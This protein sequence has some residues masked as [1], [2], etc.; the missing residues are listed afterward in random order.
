MGLLETL[1]TIDVLC[2]DKTG[3]L[4]QNKMSLK[5]LFLAGE[6]SLNLKNLSSGYKD[7]FLKIISYVNSAKLVDGIL[8]GDPEDIALCNFK[9]SSK[10]KFDK[11]DKNIIS[12]EPF[13]SESKYS[14]S[15]LKS[16]KLRLKKGAPEV[17][18]LSSKFTILNGK[19]VTLNSK[20]RE[21][22]LDKMREYSNNSLRP[23]GFSYSD[24]TGS[25]EVF[26][27]F[28][29]LYDAPKKGIK[30]TIEKIY[31]ANIEIKMITG[32]GKETAVAI[33]KECGFRDIKSINYYELVKLNK[34]EFEKV[35]LTYNV[36]ARMTPQFKE[37]ILTIL[38]KKGHRV[39]ITGDGVNDSMALKKADVGIVMGNGSDIAKESGDLILVNNDFNSLPMAISEGR[40]IFHNIRKV[41][42]YLLTANLAE[43]LTILVS[44]FFGFIPFTAIQILWVNFVTDIAPA[45]SLGLDKF[46]KKIMDRLPN[47]R[48]E[49]ILNLRILL[50]TLFISIKKVLLI[51]ILFYIAY[52]NSPIENNL[53]FAQSI[54]FTW[55]VISHFVR[56]SAIRFDEKVPFFSNKYVNYSLFAVLLLQIL[57]IY[58]PLNTIFNVVEIPINWLI[59]IIGFILIGI[60][61]AKFISIF[62]NYILKKKNISN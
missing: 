8:K 13:N 34:K 32:D 26:L 37:K 7:I 12:F 25:N 42:N 14:Y 52:H 51:F 60:F 3:T 36:F 38:Q 15:D 24:L 22:L 58:S 57:I 30:Q 28:C 55:L 46:P 29:G 61:L 19:K 9:K 53:V 21:I 49:K 2:S 39:A 1:G 44:S 6:D 48:N 11:D 35:V 10:F 56:I 54:S 45:M 41:V 5:R 16:E 31:S 23:I 27:G 62:I 20:N 43:V 33:A 59:T 50:L 47:G 18:L 17:L 4:T 40:G